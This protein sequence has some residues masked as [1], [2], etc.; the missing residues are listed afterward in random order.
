MLTSRRSAPSLIVDTLAHGGFE[1]VSASRGV[2]SIGI[3]KPTLYTEPGLFLGRP[4][5]TLYYGSVQMMPF[6]RPHFDELLQAIDFAIDK[7]YPAR[8]E[9]AGPLTN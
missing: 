6:A 4:D 5:G 9:Y 7:N 2:T 1:L 3:E 8:G